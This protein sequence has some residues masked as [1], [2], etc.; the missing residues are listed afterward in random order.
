M[1]ALNAR[2]LSCLTLVAGMMASTSAHAVWTFGQSGVTSLA[3]CTGTSSGTANTCASG[4]KVDNTT[5][6]LAGYY[7]TNGTNNAGLSAGT[8]WS[9]A[10]LLAYS[11]GQGINSDGTTDPNHAVDN[12]ARTEGVL[13]SFSGSV[14]L[15]SIGVGYTASAYCRNNTTNAITFPSTGDVCASG[16][17]RISTQT[18]GTSG[19]DLS[20]FRWVGSGAPTLSGTSASTMS[21]WQLVGNYGDIGVDTSNPYNLVNSK[22]LT[23]SYWLVSAYNSGFASTANVTESR[24]AL[25]NGDDYFKLY[26]VAATTTGR[27]PEPATLALTGAALVGVAGLRRRKAKPSA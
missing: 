19:V 23:S 3:N 1:K 8:T 14:A 17:T 26:A 10:P 24:G 20:L 15:S 2:W 9:T 25:T 22:N 12:N 21:G 4:S 18:D 11:G 27:L 6:S 13:L 7:V 5:V 16:T